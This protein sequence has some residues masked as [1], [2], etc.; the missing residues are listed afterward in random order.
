LPI[1]AIGFIF[2]SGFWISSNIMS[3]T[4]IALAIGVVVDD[5]IVMVENAYR[6]ISEKQEEMDNNQSTDEKLFKR[7]LKEHDPLSADERMK[8]IESSSKLVGPGV[9]IQHLL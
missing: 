2:S 4:G 5:G 3:L 9:F 8:L 1:S 6:T 7:Y